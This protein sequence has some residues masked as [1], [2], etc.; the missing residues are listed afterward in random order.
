VAFAGGRLTVAAHREGVSPLVKVA[1]R[2]EVHE[3]RAGDRRTFEPQPDPSP[4]QQAQD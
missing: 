2:D 3:L 1:V 4:Q